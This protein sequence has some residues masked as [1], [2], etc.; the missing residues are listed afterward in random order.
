MISRDRDRIKPGSVLER[1]LDEITGQTHAGGGWKNVSP[2]GDILLQDII[3]DEL[4]RKPNMKVSVRAPEILVSL[5]RFGLSFIDDI[6]D[7]AQL[8]IQS[9]RGGQVGI[10]Q[11]REP[12]PSGNKIQLME[13]IDQ[14]MTKNGWSRIVAV[15]E[16]DQL[17]L[18]Y[19]PQDMENPADLEA[20]TIVLS[21]EELVIV[22][23][24]GDLRPIYQLAHSH[25]GEIPPGF[26]R[27]VH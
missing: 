26:G 23:A 6:D 2:T 4:P 8:A 18:V 3:L 25:I 24:S 22:S 19:A 15:V 5:A 9:V 10:Y 27:K 21:D 13:R 12:V 16:R 17:V 14:S 1:P 7:E 20:L 11:L